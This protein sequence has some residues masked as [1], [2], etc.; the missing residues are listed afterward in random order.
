VI[1]HAGSRLPSSRLHGEQWSRAKLCDA[2]NFF[3]GTMLFFSPWLFDLPAGPPQHIAVII[4]LLIALSSIAALIAYAGW[5]A[6][7]NLIA[8]LGLIAASWPLGLEDKTAIKLYTV[9][10]ALVVA[11]AALELWFTVDRQQRGQIGGTGQSRT[12][13]GSD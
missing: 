13:Q 8:G 6:W 3:M 7:F 5:E 9:I 10:G 12:N 2:A 11:L 4:G 1:V